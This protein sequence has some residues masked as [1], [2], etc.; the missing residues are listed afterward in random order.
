[1]SD[2]ELDLLYLIEELEGALEDAQSTMRRIE[3]DY[4]RWSKY[5]KK[6]E[7]PKKV[8]VDEEKYFG[9]EFKG[10]TGYHLINEDGTLHGWKYDSKKEKES[11]E[12]GKNPS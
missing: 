2:A 7:W 6:E 3:Y 9:S 12:N 4:R 10:C 5:N 8:Y 1:M 11:D